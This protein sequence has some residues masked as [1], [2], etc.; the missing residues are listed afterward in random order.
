MIGRPSNSALARFVVS[1]DEQ[2]L[3][4]VPSLFDRDVVR[5]V[6]PVSS[7][8]KTLA[9]ITKQ[10][11]RRSKSFVHFHELMVSRPPHGETGIR[12]PA[13]TQLTGFQTINRSNA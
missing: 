1:F 4:R 13:G 6:R 10:S 11:H 9:K 2:L 12:A 3:H 5:I 7:R 8:N